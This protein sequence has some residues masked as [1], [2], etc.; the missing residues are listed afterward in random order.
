MNEQWK[1]IVVN[2]IRGVAF[3][4]AGMKDARHRN[5][6]YHIL[7]LNDVVGK[8]NY[9]FNNGQIMHTEEGSLFYLPKGSSYSAK[10]I[11]PGSCHAISFDAD[12]VDTPFVMSIQ[13]H[14][15]LWENMKIA[16]K[17]W[18]SNEDFAH[19]AA[20]RALYD[21][22]YR[23]VKK[24]ARTYMPSERFAILAPALDVIKNDFT[25]NDLSITYLASLCDISDVYFRR[26]FL[27][28]YGVLPKEYIIQRRIEYAKNLLLS[29]AFS[30]KTIAELCGYAEPCHFSRE[31]TKRVGVSPS[32]FLL[33]KLP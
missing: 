7:V 17:A 10:V 28:L 32:D 1:S 19:G 13:K 25:R 5:R 9:Y 12:I 16:E 29:E 6:P 22:I 21:V 30:I 4:P 14:E 11:E 27:N 20:M 23:I 8:K 26:L 24:Q 18:K 15:K 33:G 2:K 31:F 3:V